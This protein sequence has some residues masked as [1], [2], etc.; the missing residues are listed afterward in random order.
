MHAAP[1][2]R[3]KAWNSWQSLFVVAGAVALFSAF[4]LLADD[5]KTKAIS[6][7][8]FTAAALLGWGAYQL[9]R[10]HITIDPDAISITDRKGETRY[11]FIQATGF[12]FTHRLSGLPRRAHNV[13]FSLTGHGYGLYFGTGVGILV[14]KKTC[15]AIAALVIPLASPH[16]LR[17]ALATFK[18]GQPVAFGSLTV[19]REG[20]SYKGF[21]PEITKKGLTYPTDALNW[22]AFKGLAR[23]QDGFQLE[24]YQTQGSQPW[25][26]IPTVHIQNVGILESFLSEVATELRSARGYHPV[27]QEWEQEGHC[28]LR[29]RVH[30]NQIQNEEELQLRSADGGTYTVKLPRSIQNDNL[31]RLRSAYKNGVGDILVMVQFA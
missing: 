16:I 31:L 7:M 4:F 12:A 28:Y 19:N 2:H 15:D 18:S 27:E 26:R 11:P 20:L 30:P 1:T 13:S 10:V 23:S 29:I 22:S 21:I 9:G 14:S 3:F 6:L 5:P 8:G 25:K 17:H 24:I